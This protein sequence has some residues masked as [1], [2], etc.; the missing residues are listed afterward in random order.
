MPPFLV[1]LVYHIGLIEPVH[2]RYWKEE[3]T[4]HAR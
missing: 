3:V 1:D 2:G 4:A